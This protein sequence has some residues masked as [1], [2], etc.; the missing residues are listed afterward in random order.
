ME[1]IANIDAIYTVSTKRVTESMAAACMDVEM[2][3]SVTEIL[4]TN[5]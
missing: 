5:S 1:I 3:I 2:G 4:N